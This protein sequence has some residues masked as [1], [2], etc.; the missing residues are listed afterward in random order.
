MIDEQVAGAACCASNIHI[1][2]QRSLEA[3]PLSKLA[4][5]LVS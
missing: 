4:E 2:L 3:N 1:K 5:R